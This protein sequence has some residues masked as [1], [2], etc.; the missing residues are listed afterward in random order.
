M[1]DGVKQLYESEMGPRKKLRR[2]QENG[3]GVEA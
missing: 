1:G 3:A 2:V